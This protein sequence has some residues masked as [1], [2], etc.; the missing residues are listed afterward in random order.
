MAGAVEDMF[1]NPVGVSASFLRLFKEM[2][3][4]SGLDKPDAKDVCDQ[5][6]MPATETKSEAFFERYRGKVDEHGKPYIG[7][8]TVFLSYAWKFDINIPFEVMLAYAEEKPDTYFWFDLCINNQWKAPNRAHDWWSTTFQECIRKIGA[9]LLV[10]SPWDDPVPLTRVW[11][12]WEIMCAVASPGVDLI[13][14][15]PRAEQE[16]F[17]R[18][19]NDNFRSAMTALV[20]TQAENAESWNPAD[21]TMIF[22]AIEGTC[23]FHALN[24]A[25]KS[26]MRDWFIQTGEDL[27]NELEAE[28]KQL[29]SEFGHLCFNLGTMFKDFDA[30]RKAERRFD[31]CLVAKKHLHGDDSFKL[32]ETYNNMAINYKKAGFVDKALTAYENSLRLKL[33]DPSVGPNHV[34]TAT[35]YNN[36]GSYR[37]KPRM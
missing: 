34:K 8:A 25:V 4:Q 16:A 1:V 33:A 3:D 20:T 12:L 22:E 35:T 30:F 2:I 15:L 36:S 24:A 11:C 21:R 17:R 14:R 9:V 23:G 37:R 29:T 18:E 27:A 32:A 19:I 6:V 13:V 26:H 28:G 5:L 31:Q 10:L 7:P